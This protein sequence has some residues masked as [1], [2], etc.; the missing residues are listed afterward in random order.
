MGIVWVLVG[1]VGG[2]LLG[3]AEERAVM[4]MGKRFASGRAG[5]ET[6]GFV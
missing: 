6:V 3:A 4:M 2:W 5:F 1:F